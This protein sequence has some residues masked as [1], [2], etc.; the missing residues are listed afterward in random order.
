MPIRV[1][2]DPIPIVVIPEF[3][4]PFARQISGILTDS[5]VRNASKFIAFSAG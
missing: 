1:Y 4:A 5:I 3:D 2:Y